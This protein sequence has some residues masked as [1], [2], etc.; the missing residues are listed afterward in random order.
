MKTKVSIAV[1]VAA[2]CA[3]LAQINAQSGGETIQQASLYVAPNGNDAWSGKNAEPKDGDEP[4]LNIQR[5]RDEIREIKKLR[6]L[7][8]GGIVVE[9]RGGA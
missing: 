9:I 3:T 5:A 1:S 6:G 8:N 7:P 4:Y 2:M